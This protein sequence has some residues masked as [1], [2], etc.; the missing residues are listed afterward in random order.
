MQASGDG[1]IPVEV[2]ERLM[3]MLTN[4][5]R[6]SELVELEERIRRLEEKR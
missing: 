5:A 1:T 3:S 4:A 6:I 2:G